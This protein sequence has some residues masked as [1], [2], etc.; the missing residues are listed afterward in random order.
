MNAYQVARMQ[1]VD[2]ISRPAPNHLKNIK[3]NIGNQMT[4]ATVSAFVGSRES[5]DVMNNYM[6][7]AVGVVG[8]V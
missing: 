5:F 2:R 1:D 6:D 3:K 7:A 4:N 8:Q